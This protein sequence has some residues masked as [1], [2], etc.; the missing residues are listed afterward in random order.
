MLA[1]AIDG[2]VCRARVKVTRGCANVIT[3]GGIGME[4]EERALP[5]K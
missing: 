2:G 3:R 4:W 1:G 5:C